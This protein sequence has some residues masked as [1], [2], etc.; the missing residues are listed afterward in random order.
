MHKLVATSDNELHFFG[1]GEGG[2]S[3][4]KMAKKYV[5]SSSQWRVSDKRI[6]KVWCIRCL[7]NLLIDFLECA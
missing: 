1:S 3:K 2:V 6:A 7:S 5:S 4:Y